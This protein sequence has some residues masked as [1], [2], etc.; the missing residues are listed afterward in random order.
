[1]LSRVKDIVWGAAHIE[2]RSITEPA[3]I[4]AAIVTALMSATII[5]LDDDLI[6]VPLT[7]GAMF[8][9]VVDAA[10]GPAQRLRAMLWT[11]GWVALAG[12]AGGFA[13]SSRGIDLVF[14][15]VAGVI[16]GFAGA[17]GRLG[18]TV[19]VLALVMTTLAIAVPSM[20]MSPL[21]FGVLALA[22]G[23]VQTAVSVAADLIRHPREVFAAVPDQQPVLR[24]LRAH[25]STDDPIFRHALR[26][27]AA[28]LVG[29]L[30]S[31][32]SGM[33]H[34]N[35]IPLTV[36][37]LSKPNAD[38]YGSRILARLA[39]TIIGIVAVVVIVDVFHVQSIGFALL[40]GAGAYVAIA[41]LAANYAIAVIG[42]TTVL[43]SLM[44]IN[45]EPLIE[46]AL[47]RILATI[48]GSAIV[49][50]APL[51]YPPPRTAASA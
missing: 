17:L 27:G 48:I 45:H 9:G 13:A 16:C 1:M 12:A 18:T 43:L 22:G 50:L 15:A 51:V 40:I 8:A 41:F 7:V 46:T 31:D 33:T 24:R 35:W 26:L 36:A 39:G 5:F 42:I 34:G 6:A 4:R 29:L 25:L 14:I 38:G 47:M 44:T 49:I 37:W 11:S 10:G 3:A 19:G 28:M 21:T 23:L 2:K 20:H 32:L 30:I